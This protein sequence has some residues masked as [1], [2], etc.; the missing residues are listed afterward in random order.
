MRNRLRWQ[1]LG[2]AAVLLVAAVAG[3]VPGSDAASGVVEVGAGVGEIAALDPAEGSTAGPADG[4]VAEDEHATRSRRRMR[5]TTSMG[6][7]RAPRRMG[8]CI[9]RYCA[10]EPRSSRSRGPVSTRPAAWGGR[11]RT[12]RSS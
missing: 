9:G 7:R 5:P 6:P 8:G 4:V 2:S 1:A 11:T 12:L 3:A 10:S